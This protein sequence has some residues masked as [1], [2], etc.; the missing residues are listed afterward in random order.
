MSL[1]RQFIRPLI[2]CAVLIGA[3]S[4]LTAC[5]PLLIGGAAA[6]TGLV[7]VDRRTVGE[8][9][10]DKSIELKIGGQLRENFGDAVRA[11][12][13]SYDGVVLLTG[14]TISRDFKSSATEIARK[15]ENVKSVSNQLDVVKDLASFGVVSNDIWITSK[16]MTTLATTKDIPSR[17][18]VVTTD[19]GVV[20][21]MGLV[22]QREGDMAAA[23]AAKVSGV[24]RVEKL[25]QIVTPEEAKRLDNAARIGS[26][27]AKP[28]TP[29]GE[30]P[31]SGSSP[32]GGDAPPAGGVQV[33][34]IQ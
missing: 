27:N 21:L 9:I 3:G 13:T 32:M 6:T 5:I 8:Q 24:K 12:I 29:L 31:V 30:T 15:V 4:T 23:A 11:T 25:F 26:N 14:D 19:R 2:L 18:I 20:Y 28:T 33:M 17:T 16:V 7:V 34:P 22:T 10:D 1:Q